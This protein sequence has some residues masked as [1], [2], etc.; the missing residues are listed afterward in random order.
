LRELAQSNQISANLPAFSAGFGAAMVTGYICI[1]FLM[2][3]LQR[4]KLYVFAL[5]CLIFGGLNLAWL[6]LK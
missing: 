6:W 4:R 3:F 1:D 2:K 5:Y